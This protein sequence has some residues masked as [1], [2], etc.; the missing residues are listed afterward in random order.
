M[1]AAQLETWLK[2]RP[3]PAHLRCKLD[4]GETRDVALG[5]V[6]SWA[7]VAETVLTLETVVL[8]ALDQDRVLLRATRL[9]DDEADDQ[10][11]DGEEDLDTRAPH[12]PP[13]R[14][15]RVSSIDPETQRFQ[16]Y[17]AGISEAYKHATGVA[18]GK[19]SELVDSITQ[20]YETQEKTLG[21]LQAI[22]QDLTEQLAEAHETIAALQAQPPAA[23][24]DPTS[25]EGLASAFAQGAIL[26]NQ[27]TPATNGAKPNGQHQ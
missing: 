26:G 5:A 23:G 22:I 20:R 3:R 12:P 18:F 17:A 13:S 8:E 15:A 2:R 27:P 19:Y 16:T 6:R 25:L 24:G 4:G 21:H 14:G 7:K 11:D 9:D 10:T 1:H